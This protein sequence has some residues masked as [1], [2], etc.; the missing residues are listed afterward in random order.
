MTNQPK[1]ALQD[2]SELKKLID[3]IK[4]DY[5]F[6]LI[7]IIIALLIAFLIN[8]YTTPKYK[9][10]SSV[11]IKEE[12]N[13]GVRDVNEYINNGLFGTKQNLQNELWVLKSSPVIEQTVKNLDLAVS[14]N[15]KDGL[16]TKDAYKDI[17]FYV[18]LL[19]DH[20]QPVNVNFTLTIIDKSN[21]KIKAQ[22]KNA[23]FKNLYTNEV[24]YAKKK[25]LF[26]YS[27]EFGKLI[28][29]PDL[30]FIIKWDTGNLLYYKDKDYY[31]F[32]FKDIP[33]LT[34]FYKNS[35]NFNI[36]DKN[37]TIIELELK[38]ESISKAKDILNE[39]MDVHSQQNL[40]RK[41]HIA[42]ITIDYIDR[43][44]DEIS[45]SL[46]Q[47]ED[48]LQS[49]RASNQ[50]LDISEQASGIST[51]YMNLQ[52]QLAELVTRK[53]YYDYVA[54]Y[55]DNN[56]N[57]NDF[58]NMMVPASIGIQDQIL[59]NL[60]SDLIT[61][62]AQRSNL[63]ANQQEKNPLI[64]KLEVQIENSRKTISENIS[65]VR[66]TT[67]IS[68]D[69]MN[70]RI[71]KVE[72]QINRLPHTQRLLGGIER[73]YRLNDAIYNYLLEKRAEAKISQA[74]NL[75]DN[76]II[77]PSKMKGTGPISP[78]KERNY[79]AALFL[80][81]TIPFGLILFRKAVNN[82]I[83]SQEDIEDISDIPVLGK[84]LHNRKKSSNVVFEFPKSNITE[85]FRSLRTNIE[86]QLKGFRKKVILVTS[87]I[88]GEGKTFTALNLAM[89]YAQLGRKTILLDFDLRKNTQYFERRS[90]SVSGISTYLNGITDAEEIIQQT[91][92]NRLDYIPSGPVPPNPVELL[93]QGNIQDLIEQIKNVYD[94]I[95]IDTAPLAQVSDAYLLFDYSDIKIIVT[96][97]N[98]S[99]KRVF[100]LIMKDLQKKN[101][102]HTCVVLNDNRINSDQYGYG[103][104][105]SKKENK[106]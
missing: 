38:S 66:K 10:A 70:K 80:G 28:E 51:Q 65:A 9:V 103:Y 73:K 15:Y 30:A 44:L 8:I 86:F 34:E 59:N 101:I 96:R 48:N 19:N 82:K 64:Q 95:I 36:I 91:D 105:Y 18:L 35:I 25:W 46:T 42:N 31:G 20:I 43:Q 99:L 23:V 7:G 92:D 83:V 85:S 76:V 50:L 93:A 57:N 14:Y 87:C 69:E 27:G 67:E 104:G 89:S 58:S 21:F 12:S 84:I 71:K 1:I 79:L 16:I 54:D 78:N 40:D 53:R 5:Y 98:I 39:L 45:E 41:N 3:L 37:A 49:F 24:S 11:L 26:E 100:S 63:I 62:Q 52:N 90:D 17:P 94:C 6:F 56:N 81:V 47:T 60:M 29:T 22:S 75:P 2:S 77:E 72:A 13:Q 4:K 97:V 74:S 61:A 55:L 33:S 68:I 106:R 32:Y 102:N 88:E